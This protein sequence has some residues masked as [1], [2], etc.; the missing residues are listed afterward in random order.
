MARIQ[1]NVLMRR[2]SNLYFSPDEIYM[3]RN[4]N[5][6]ATDYLIEIDTVPISF[7]AFFHI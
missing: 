4:V 7:H 1:L 6:C 5:V 3:S 2:K